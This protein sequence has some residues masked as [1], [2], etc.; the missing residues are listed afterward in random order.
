[1]RPEQTQADPGTATPRAA[2][3]P[4]AQAL[5]SSFRNPEARLLRVSWGALG[6][7]GAAR[8]PW[9]AAECGGEGPGKGRQPNSPQSEG[10]T[11]IRVPHWVPFVVLRAAPSSVP[12]I[13]VSSP[14][15]GITRR[16]VRILEDNLLL[17]NLD[18]QV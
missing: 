14:G 6:S 15:D 18:L 17:V 12:S 13:P 8:Q 5:V 11:L 1:M 2:P 9:Q 7:R 3:R 10:S 16:A 4:R